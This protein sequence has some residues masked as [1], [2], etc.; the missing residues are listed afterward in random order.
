M[1]GETNAVN[2]ARNVV[3]EEVHQPVAH[4]IDDNVEEAV[5]D[6]PI[7]NRRGSRS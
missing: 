6:A 1:E 4:V 7:P 3:N 2:R 5:H